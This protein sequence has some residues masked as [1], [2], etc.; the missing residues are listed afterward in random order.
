MN[1]KSISKTLVVMFLAIGLSTVITSCEA[2]SKANLCEYEGYYIIS[3]FK[4]ESGCG[5]ETK[6]Y[7]YL[8]NGNKFESI[9]VNAAI[10]SF[11]EKEKPKEGYYQIIC[12][13]TAE[14]KDKL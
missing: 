4:E 9:H 11:Y 1:I 10:W 3:Q 5:C 7:L 14:L 12:K 8:K 13:E 2:K 6:H